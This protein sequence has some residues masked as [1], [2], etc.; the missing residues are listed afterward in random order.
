M[1]AEEQLMLLGEADDAEEALALVLGS[2]NAAGAAPPQLYAAPDPEE[3][4]EAKRAMEEL[5]FLAAQNQHALLHDAGLAP[6]ATAAVL[7]RVQNF[8]AHGVLPLGGL[9]ELDQFL[10]KKIGMLAHCGFEE[11]MRLFVPAPEVPLPDLA[12]EQEVELE[13][14]QEL[15][16][17]GVQVSKE[18]MC[19]MRVHLLNETETHVFCPA[20]SRAWSDNC[21][22]VQFAN[23][24]AI[25]RRNEEAVVAALRGS[26]HSLLAAFPTSLAEDEALLSRA[27]AFGPVRRAAVQ[28][29]RREK[30]LLHGGLRFLDKHEHALQA[31]LVPFQLERMVAERDAARGKEAARAELADEVRRRAAVLAGRAPL[32]LVDV[33]LGARLGHANLTL[34][35]G[36]DVAMA[37]Q[38]FM[39]AHNVPASYEATLRQALVK[40]VPRAPPLELLLGV[41]TPLGERRVLALPE[42]ANVAVETGVFC[43]RFNITRHSQC[44]AVEQ[45]VRHLLGRELPSEGEIAPQL[46]YRRTLLLAVPV[47]APDTRKLQLRVWEGEQ[48]A[49]QQLCTD[50]F[51]HYELDTTQAAAM[52]QVVEQRLPP[53]VL[54]IPVQLSGRRQI[55]VRVAAGDNITAVV[56]AFAR[57]MELT[58]AEA[59]IKLAVL[60]RARFGMAPGSF[61]L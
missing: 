46:P 8:F 41:V 6:N 1:S 10:L 5:A 4:P 12:S 20:D 33:D 37:L 14:E 60:K 61:L 40:A 16:D 54:R 30:G 58:E 27:D 26:F 43:A 45:R 35:A 7:A 42:G 22:D 21:H 18:L 48:H 2:E 29:R 34:H 19:A 38:S 52:A 17:G 24:T 50:F 13:Q 9:D 56:E 23:F 3:D 32:A 47:D 44:D 15:A 57:V 53:A 36:Q 11:Q 55:S 59:E 49:L 51:E 25:S 31:G 28:L 39:H